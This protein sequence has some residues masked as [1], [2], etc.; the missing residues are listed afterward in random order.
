MKPTAATAMTAATVAT[1]PSR[2][3][4]SQDM[5]PTITFEPAGSATWARATP[6]MAH[7]ADAAAAARGRRNLRMLKLLTAGYGKG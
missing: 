7:W 4:W 3:P 5:A 2:V 6:A 1:V